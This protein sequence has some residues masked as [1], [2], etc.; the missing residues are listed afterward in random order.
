M[1]WRVA[2]IWECETKAKDMLVGRIIEI[3][4]MQ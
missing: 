2:I 1:D 4:D 3:F